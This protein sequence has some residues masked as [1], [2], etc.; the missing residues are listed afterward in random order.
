MCILYSYNQLFDMRPSWWD[1]LDS[2]RTAMAEA[3]GQLHS[4]QV[5]HSAL[6]AIK[7][8]KDPSILHLLLQLCS[9]VLWTSPAQLMIVFLSIKATVSNMATFNPL[10]QEDNAIDYTHMGPQIQWSS[11]CLQPA[12]R[13]LVMTCV[14]YLYSLLLL[15]CRYTPA[16][17]KN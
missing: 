7:I 17:V 6:A 9:T 15:S 3:T 8:R 10:I 5:S 1:S 11:R 14:S 4:C 12:K 2:P 13:M 16:K